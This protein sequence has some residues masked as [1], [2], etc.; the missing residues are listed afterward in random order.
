MK[1]KT[2]F[3]LVFSFFLIVSCN[4]NSFKSGGNVS[5]ATGWKINSKDG[6]FQLNNKFKDQITAPG[7]L[8]SS[9]GVQ[10]RWGYRWK[11]AVEKLCQDA[12]P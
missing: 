9:F 6:G 5:A 4:K 8:F 10:R 12:F 3:L 2:L 1:N 7:M 11:A